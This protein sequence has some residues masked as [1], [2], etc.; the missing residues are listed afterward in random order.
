MCAI[1]VSNEQKVTDARWVACL[2][3]YNLS[4]YSSCV[5][6]TLYYTKSNIIPNQKSHFI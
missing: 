5:R 4:K 1:I 2:K 3:P 6:V